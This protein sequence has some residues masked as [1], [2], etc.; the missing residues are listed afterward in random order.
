VDDD[1]DDDDD[2]NNN[3]NNNVSPVHGISRAV[4]AHTRHILLGR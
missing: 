3:N 4:P 2:N 1:D